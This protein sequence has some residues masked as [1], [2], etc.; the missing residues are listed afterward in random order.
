MH[1]DHDDEDHEEPG[2]G[3]AGGVARPGAMPTG[4]WTRM[5]AS[6]QRMRVLQR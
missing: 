1:R 3:A 4:S 5:H 2:G 6:Y